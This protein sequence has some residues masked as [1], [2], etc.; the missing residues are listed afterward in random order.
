MSGNVNLSS[1]VNLSGNISLSDSISL[2]C[3]V[4]LY[5]NVNLSQTI[6]QITVRY[7]VILQALNI[8]NGRQGASTVYGRLL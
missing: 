6:L 8:A 5:G 1:N 2:S 4:N 7:T 3:S